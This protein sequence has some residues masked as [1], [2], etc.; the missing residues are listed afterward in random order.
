MGFSNMMAVFLAFIQI[1]LYKYKFA[2]S[3]TIHDSICP[4]DEK[5]IAVRVT[6]Y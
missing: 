6:Y 1:N 3:I 2:V 5:N 4:H